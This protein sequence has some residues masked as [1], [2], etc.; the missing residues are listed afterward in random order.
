M[1]LSGVGIWNHGLRYGDKAESADAAAE[2]DELGY[3]AL[4]IPDVGGT[5]VLDSVDHLLSATNDIVIATGILNLTDERPFRRCGVL[6]LV[7]APP[8]TATGSSW[9]SASATHR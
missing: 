5:P 2:L 6:R 9:A 4:W 3:T 1:D 7:T 8:R